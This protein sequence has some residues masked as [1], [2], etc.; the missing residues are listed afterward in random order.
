MIEVAIVE[1]FDKIFMAIDG[2]GTF[3]TRDQTRKV[4]DDYVAEFNKFFANLK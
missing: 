1:K 2:D 4:L 3:M